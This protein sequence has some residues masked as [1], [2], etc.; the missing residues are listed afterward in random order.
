MFLSCNVTNYLCMHYLALSL[1]LFWVFFLR[2]YLFIFREG[3]GKRKRGRETSACGCLLCTCHWGPGL[4]PRHE[5]WL[6]IKTM[7]L[8]FTGRPALSPMSHTSQGA[9]PGFFTS[10]C[11]NWGLRNQCKNDV[12]L[13]KI[14]SLCYWRNKTVLFL[15]HRNL[16]SSASIHEAGLLV[17]K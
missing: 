2:F 14:A 6:G 8:W 5:P 7:T 11:G 3:K 4:Q 15:W 12:I 10:P 16:V 9:L 17:C 1:A 13:A